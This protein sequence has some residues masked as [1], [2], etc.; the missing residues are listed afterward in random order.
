[1]KRKICLSF[2]ALCSCLLLAPAA[3]GQKHKVEKVSVALTAAGDKI[4][5]PRSIKPVL[6]NRIRYRVTPKTDTTFTDG[7]SLALPFIPQIPEAQAAEAPDAGAS[8]NNRMRLLMR[9]QVDEF[10]R[11]APAAEDQFQAIINVLD[12]YERRKVTEVQ[13]PISRL[14]RDT[15]TARDATE[16]FVRDSDSLL[17][18]GTQNVLGR[19]PGLIALINE[20]GRTP[21]PDTQI[22]DISAGLSILK[23]A[24]RRISD[25]N[26]LTANRERVNAVES[27]IDS[28]RQELA[29]LS[30]NNQADSPA[31]K[32]DESQSALRG[33]RD[34]FSDAHEQGAGYFELPYIDVGCGF[35]FNQNKQTIVSLVMV[36]R[37]GEEA[38][39]EKVIATVICSSPLS[40]SGGFGFSTLDEKEFV[41]VPSIKTVTENGQTTDQVIKRFGFKNSSSFRA[42]PVLL[43]NTRIYEPNDTL[44]FHMSAGA[45]VDIKT[46]QAGTDLEFIVGPS[47]SFKRT[48]FFTAGAHIG[49]VPKLAGGF[50]LDQEVPE[51]V[52]EPPIEKAWKT[53]FIFT[54]TYKLK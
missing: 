9:G 21:W 20:S 6:V 44:A 28:L 19:L 46:G 3:F 22:N 37:L 51:S 52:S 45:G 16:R 23:N 32:Y 17:A 26:W 13:N 14:L 50:E 8:V 24:L 34:I 15:K 18:G 48:L 33:W 31:T 41:F 7:P 2:L 11:A 36:D 29:A 43:L 38:R 4:R 10:L 27:R 5:G 47:V 25:G 49:R 39:Q 40:I 42:I 12:T 1:M 30:H 35:G 54:V 53:G